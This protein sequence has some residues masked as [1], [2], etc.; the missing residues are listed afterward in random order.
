M[1]R[2]RAV[3]VTRPARLGF[4]ALVIAI[5]LAAGFYLTLKL[6]RGSGGYQ[7]GVRFRQAAGVAP[8]AQ[9]Y[10]NGVNVGGVGKVQILPDTTVD[11]IINIYRDT[12]IPK[13]AKFTVQTSLTGTPSVTI[14]VPPGAVA[15]SEVWPKRVLPLPEQPAG[16]LPLTLEDF[17]GQ[18]RALGD[19]A[20][21]VLGQARP[22]GGRL[23]HH[24]QN[25]RANGAATMQDLHETLPS[26]MGTLQTT[27]ATAKANAND[28]QA[29][30]R[31]HDEAKLRA[32]ADA[33]ERTTADMQKTAASLQTIKRDPQLASNTRAATAQL[34][35][36]MANMA[37]LSRDMETISGNPQTK[38]ELRDAGARL[39][40][41]LQKI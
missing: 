4:A 28:A 38:A 2:T 41:L 22:Y 16:V 13:T 14:T 20:Q 34:H 33:F 3:R 35:Q 37:K 39:R 18:S 19:R 7:I 27:I 40:A 15:A 26:L 24:L 32:I 12:A 9:V 25:A 17:M 5:L 8:G 30:L 6:V 23:M 21:R 1:A 31:G 10:M 36:V 11:F 29:A